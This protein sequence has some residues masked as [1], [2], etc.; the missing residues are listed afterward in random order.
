MKL[1]TAACCLALIGSGAF[2]CAAS[3][4]DN[5]FD[6]QPGSGEGSAGN[7]GGVVVDEGGGGGST[8]TP[9]PPSKGN[10]TGVVRAPEG[11]IPI[12]GALVYL[13][14]S[15]PPAIPD[16]VYCDAC[17][18]LTSSTPHTLTG[19]NG[20]FD[21]PTHLTGDLFLV[22]QK[23]Q[24]RRVRQVTINEGTQAM[25]AAVTTL[26]ARM[27][28][29]NGDDV[30]RM[31]LIQGQWDHIEVSL[32]KLGLANIT[33][34]FLGPEVDTANA[35]FDFIDSGARD[36]LLTNWDQIKNYHIV[37]IPCSGSSGTTC[38]DSLPGN[39]QVQE[40]LRQFVRAG[41]KL[42]AT[43]YSYEFVRQPW[44]Q[45]VTFNSANGSIGSGC[46]SFEYDAP[47]TV[48]DAGMRD[49]LAAQNPPIT[50]FDVVAN[51]T[52][53]DALNAGPV[54]DLDGNSINTTPK[55]W[56]SGLWQG[57]NHPATVS[58]QDQCGRVMFST[59]HTEGGAGESTLLPQE[60][61]LLYV[62]LEV[63]V[64]VT[65]PIPT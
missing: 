1:K 3:G 62:I 46:L 17:E 2:G 18:E 51:Y 27:D 42:Y 36:G 38:N 13:S 23:G 19:A 63:G 57:G 37:F 48:N 56:V 20:Y 32:A 49:W 33:E 59:Y 6:N 65:E 5:E 26:P 22:V 64:C 52:M 28:K 10:V 4:D 43:D 41:G 58:F 45:L 24:F 55:N 21:L 35:A 7:G 15:A 16:G 11:T 54:L 9:P 53:V 12:S 29:A 8:D 31:A 39:A 30:P 25:P 14:Q 44:P 61:A 47:A 40:N 60:L 50:N 34:G